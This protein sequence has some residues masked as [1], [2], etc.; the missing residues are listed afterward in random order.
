MEGEITIPVP[1]YVWHTGSVFAGRLD[2]PEW[3]TEASEGEDKKLMV[4][5]PM[6]PR[7]KKAVVNVYVNTYDRGIIDIHP[8]DVIYQL[9]D[10]SLGVLLQTQWPDFLAALFTQIKDQ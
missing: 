10:G 4:V 5:V 1:H 8:T 9:A 6:D 3:L 2:F 7:S